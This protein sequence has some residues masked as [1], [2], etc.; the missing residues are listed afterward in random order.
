MQGVRQGSKPFKSQS[1]EEI[2]VTSVVRKKLRIFLSL[3]SLKCSEEA[4]EVRITSS[5]QAQEGQAMRLAQEER[6]SSRS[7]RSGEV[8]WGITL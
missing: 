6:E 7:I 5:G 1:S 2:V 8:A 4:S 3:N